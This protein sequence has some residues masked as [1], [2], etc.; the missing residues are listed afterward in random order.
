MATLTIT[1]AA[2]QPYLFGEAPKKTQTLAAALQ[3]IERERQRPLATAVLNDA[4]GWVSRLSALTRNDLE[5]VEGLLVARYTGDAAR[6][7]VSGYD[8]CSNYIL[9]QA[10]ARITKGELALLAQYPAAATAIQTSST[11]ELSVSLLEEYLMPSVIAKVGLEA[12]VQSEQ[13]SG[14][15]GSASSAV[16]CKGLPVPARYR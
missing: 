15:F 13:R 2:E 11:R 5:V 4:T 10:A 16:A 8:R 9:G 12:V 3:L 6:S 7:T 1:I 14:E